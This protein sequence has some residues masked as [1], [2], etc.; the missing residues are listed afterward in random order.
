MTAG[1]ET[2]TVP[3]GE[4]ARLT[5][6]SVKTLRHYHDIGLLVPIEVDPHTGYRRYA[7]D[8]APRAH[9]IRRLR[10]LDMPLPQI[11]AMLSASDADA[12]DTALRAHLARMEDQLR[13][14]RD[15]IASL[16]AMLTPAA[17][18]P[19]TYRTVAAFPAAALRGVIAREDAAAW[20]GAAFPRL[21]AA[22]AAAGLT[23]AGPAGS[24]YSTDFF[25][26]DSGEVLAYLPIPPGTDRF[27]DGVDR[28]E[29]PRR[30]FAVAVH[31]GGFDGIDRTYGALGGHVAEHDTALPAP[32]REIYRVSPAEAADPAD[33]VTEICWPIVG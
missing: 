13:R 20:S 4:F 28:V 15:V 18:T 30:R 10:A 22:V 31:R 23:P 9:L 5:R 3:I 27:G 8:Q 32:I 25:E 24:A 1:R 19:V 16:R 2:A 6:L 26:H 17:P 29:L 33:Y 21:A 14:T 12:R 7:T 11:E